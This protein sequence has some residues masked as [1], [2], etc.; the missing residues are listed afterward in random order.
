MGVRDG[1]APARPPKPIRPPPPNTANPRHFAQYK[2]HSPRSVVMSSKRLQLWISPPET[3]EKGSLLGT[4]F[5]QGF[6]EFLAAHPTHPQIWE[7]VR[8]LRTHMPI[9]RIS[10]LWP[11]VALS[12]ISTNA[13]ESPW[14]RT[15][16]LRRRLTRHMRGQPISLAPHLPAAQCRAPPLHISPGSA[17]TTVYIFTY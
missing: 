13:S 5:H 6:S 12:T 8:R 1:N 4:V 9:A 17:T 10:P 11:L 16:A 7:R 14:G 15:S 2:H 3:V